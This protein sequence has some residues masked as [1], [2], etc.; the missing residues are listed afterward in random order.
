VRTPRSEEWREYADL[1]RRLRP[2]PAHRPDAPD[3]LLPTRLGNILR[4]AES[5]PRDR[6]ELD[7]VK[8]W[9]AFWLVLPESTKKELADARTRLDAGAATW[10]WSLLFLV[11]TVWAWWA[12]LASVAGML[13]AYVWAI[14]AAGSFGELVGAAFDVHRRELYKALHWPLPRNAAEERARGRALTEYL[15]WGSDSRDV[16]FVT[17]AEQAEIT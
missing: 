13:A 1:D 4:A 7:A 6:Y 17:P 5:H 9:P 8:C 12:P 2:F 16:E 14:R 10:L 3:R 15:W 11:W